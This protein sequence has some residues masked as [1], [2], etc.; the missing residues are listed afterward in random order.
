VQHV[1]AHQVGADAGQVALG[2]FVVLLEQQIGD[3]HVQHRVAEEL[4]P[5]V[6]VGAKAAVCERADEQLALAEGV[7]Q[8]LRE[9]IKG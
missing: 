7:T 5:L 9:G 3:C 4:K 8:A 2:G 1:L 6:V